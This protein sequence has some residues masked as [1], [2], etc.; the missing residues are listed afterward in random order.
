VLSLAL[1]I[2][3]TTAIYSLVNAFLLR[4]M[5]VDRPDRLVAVSVSIPNGGN[6]IEGFSYPQWKDF[7]AEDTGLSEI[8]G[9]T[10]LPLSMTDGQM[11]ELI[12]GEMVSGYYF[13]GL[14][15]HPAL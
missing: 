7:R 14:C 6:S 8:M 3:A 1:G 9:S 13:S 12:W 10:G 4:P 15:A 11:P 2:G 5:P